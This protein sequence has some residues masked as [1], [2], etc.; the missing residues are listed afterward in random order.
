MGA[1]LG[2]QARLAPL[3]ISVTLF[4]VVVLFSTSVGVLPLAIGVCPRAKTSS[5]TTA[6]VVLAVAFGVTDAL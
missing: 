3:K 4:A 5:R 2:R 1:L 6:Q